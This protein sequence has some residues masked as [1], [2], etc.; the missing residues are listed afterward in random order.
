MFGAVS[1]S[2]T[3]THIGVAQIHNPSSHRTNS[4]PRTVCPNISTYCI[5]HSCA[6]MQFTILFIWSINRACRW[7]TTSNRILRT[8]HRHL[9]AGVNRSSTEYRESSNYVHTLHAFC[10]SCFHNYIYTRQH[11]VHTFACVFRVCVCVYVF[12]ISSMKVRAAAVAICCVW[13]CEKVIS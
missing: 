11:T 12:V 2:R 6:H 8:R 5:G 3:G 1:I 7:R 9:G 10:E 4:A 13:M